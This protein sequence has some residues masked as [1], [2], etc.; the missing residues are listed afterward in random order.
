MQMVRRIS[1]ERIESILVVEIC[2]VDGILDFNITIP[3]KKKYF[4][5][6]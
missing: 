6:E 1:A 4:Q 2:K 5:G 3:R